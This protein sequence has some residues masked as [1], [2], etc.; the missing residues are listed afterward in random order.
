MNWETQ[1]SGDA[2]SFSWDNYRAHCSG[3]NNWTVYRMNPFID[4]GTAESKR[5]AAEL[6]K[7]HSEQ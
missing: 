7:E 3:E 1:Q 2:H 6:C 5:E 4:L